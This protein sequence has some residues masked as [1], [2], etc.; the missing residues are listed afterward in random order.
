MI[1]HERNQPDSRTQLAI[2]V[3]NKISKGKQNR[4]ERS[5]AERIKSRLL[6]VSN[7][8]YGHL[9]CVSSLTSAAQVVHA[10]D[11]PLEAPGHAVSD[12]PTVHVFVFLAESVPVTEGA[13][14][15]TRTAATPSVQ[16]Y[17]A[18]IHSGHRNI[19]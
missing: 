3:D 13:S 4:L 9:G 11:V 16:R 19:Y 7:P 10:A 6:F 5:G 8:D 18:S 2:F 14:T 17:S 15:T 1:Q 12:S